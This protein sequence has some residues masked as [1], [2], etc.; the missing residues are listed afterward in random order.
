MEAF[1]SNS[2]VPQTDL[3]MFM[4]CNLKSAGTGVSLVWEKVREFRR[5]GELTLSDKIPG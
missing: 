1:V 4:S 3:T 5:Q 2:D